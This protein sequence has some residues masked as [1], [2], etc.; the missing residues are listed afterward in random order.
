MEE[1]SG[2]FPFNNLEGSDSGSFHRPG[3]SAA[4]KASRVRIPPPPPIFTFARN[5]R[6]ERIAA[7]HGMPFLRYA[8]RF[9]QSQRKR[10][11]A[12]EVVRL[13]KAQSPAE[14]GQPIFLFA[15]SGDVRRFLI[16]IARKPNFQYE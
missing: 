12:H 4:H 11:V 2:L 7:R 15:L 13:S 16:S 8:P 3:K 14:A 1:G 6:S 9:F 5:G 10:A